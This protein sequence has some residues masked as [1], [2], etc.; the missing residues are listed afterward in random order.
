MAKD[1]SNHYLK[2]RYSVMFIFII[3]I[4]LNRI[5]T[6]FENTSKVLSFENLNL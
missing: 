3:I 1:I 2:V 4:I 6:L 5:I